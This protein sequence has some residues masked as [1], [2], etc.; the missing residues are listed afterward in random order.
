M[1][2]KLIMV[3][4]RF[5]RMVVIPEMEYSQLKSALQMSKPLESQ[6]VELSKDYKQQSGIDNSYERIHQQG[7]T[8]NE[9]INLKDQLRNN[10]IN[11]TP[12]PYQSRADGLLKFISDKVDFNNKGELKDASGNS[13]EGSNLTDLIQHAV[14]DRRRNINPVGWDYF[15]D[16]LHD[17]NAPK[18]ILNYETLD[19]MRSPTRDW[20]IPTATLK[21]ISKQTIKQGSHATSNQ[22]HSTPKSVKKAK[23]RIVKKVE[24]Y[25]TLD[26][27]RAKRVK[28]EPSYLS[29]YTTK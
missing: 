20:S 23:K 3:V 27:G 15:K 5:E 4:G 17:S 22:L 18:M 13:I 19:E 7:E 9:M 10:L 11:S 12:R 1:I 24:D 21:S 28:K 14:R 25:I 26:K 16:R 6:F 8:L 2:E 29:L